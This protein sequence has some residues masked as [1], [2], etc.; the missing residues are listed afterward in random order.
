ME[1][2]KE[3]YH[4]CLLEFISKLNQSFPDNKSVRNCFKVREKI[5]FNKHIY[6]FQSQVTK[7]KED[8]VNKNTKICRET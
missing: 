3:S 1:A 2:L 6:Y 4:K 7:I 5:N 8:F